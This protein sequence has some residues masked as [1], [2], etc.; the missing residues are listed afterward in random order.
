MCL[1][2]KGYI[3]SLLV[4]QAG[5]IDFRGK[6][7]VR[8]TEQ[9]DMEMQEIPTEKEK[10]EDEGATE[11]MLEV[12]PERASQPEVKTEGATGFTK[13]GQTFFVL[14]LT[15]FKNTTCCG[16]EICAGT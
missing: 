1:H 7:K 3:T 6:S 8:E 15:K 5:P 13:S 2:E 12:K 4:D 11:L 16:T 10:K 9:R 14:F